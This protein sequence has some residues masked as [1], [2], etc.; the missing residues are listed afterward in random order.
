VRSE[1][2]GSPQAGLTY[3]EYQG[4]DWLVK[5]YTFVYALSARSL[6]LRREPSSPVVRQLVGLGNP[7]LSGTQKTEVGRVVFRRA[8]ETGTAIPYLSPL[9]QASTEV[10]RIGQLMAGRMP[11]KI[12][13]GQQATKEEFAREAPG[14]SHLHFAVHALLNDEQ[15][16]Y[17]ALVLAPS[18]KSDGL[19]QTYEILNTRLHSRV[20]TLSGCETALGKLQRGEGLLGLQQAF[21]MAGAE[22]VVVS[23]WSIEDSTAV[24]ME[25]FYRGIRG[26][27]SFS[28]ALRSA[29]LGYLGKTLAFGNNQQVSLSHPFFWAPFVLTSTAL[30]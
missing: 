29:K 27:Q 6:S 11:T 28:S 9:P 22:A 21:L 25:D 26:G 30:Q 18:E 20:V 13:M 8:S 10:K 4:V 24:F 7:S 12:L 23:L 15:P 14:A 17:S 2:K 3:A 1:A 5:R 19:L 16:Y